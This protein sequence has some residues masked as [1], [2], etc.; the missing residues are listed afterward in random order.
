MV[1]PY[2]E[3]IKDLDK[4]K[5]LVYHSFLPSSLVFPKQGPPAEESMSSNRHP[6][7]SKR[8]MWVRKPIAGTST[9]T[10]YPNLSIQRWTCAGA[11]QCLLMIDHKLAWWLKSCHPHGVLPKVDSLRTLASQ[12]PHQ[13]QI[14]ILECF[15]IIVKPN[16][17]SPREPPS[18]FMMLFI[19]QVVVELIARK[20]SGRI[21]FAEKGVCQQRF[22]NELYD[23]IGGLMFEASVLGC[24]NGPTHVWKCPR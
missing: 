19:F 4:P 15:S 14:F 16:R 20:C 5:W 3:K 8:F 7:E 22:N 12:T 17:T 18:R 24:D 10:H 11:R 13:L 6:K 1:S 9:W 21:Y 23:D 2:P